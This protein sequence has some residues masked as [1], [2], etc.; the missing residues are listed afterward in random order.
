MKKDTQGPGEENGERYSYVS[1]KHK[2]VERTE[3]KTVCASDR[4]PAAA[5]HLNPLLC[6]GVPHCKNPDGRTYLPLQKPTSPPAGAGGAKCSMLSQ[7]PAPTGVRAQRGA[8]E[9]QEKRI[10][11]RQWQLLLVS[12]SSNADPRV[13]WGSDSTGSSPGG[14][15][16]LWVPAC[17]PSFFFFNF[18]INFVIYRMISK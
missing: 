15:L 11:P 3:E 12:H 16:I 1:K 17:F 10:H 18:P 13:Q 8:A 9:K 2:E 4:A 5:Q 7:P 14:W 6:L